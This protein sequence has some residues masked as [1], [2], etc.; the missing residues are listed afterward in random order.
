MIRASG[1][2]CVPLPC[3]H[4]TGEALTP[5]SDALVG[6][7]RNWTAW[8]RNEPVQMEKKHDARR[9]DR[10]KPLTLIHGLSSSLQL[11]T[12]LAASDLDSPGWHDVSRMTDQWLRE[13]KE[14]GGGGKTKKGEENKEKEEELLH[15]L[16]RLTCAFLLQFRPIQMG[17]KMNYF[18]WQTTQMLE[19]LD[20]CHFV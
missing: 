14:T 7:P 15:E 6:A 3:N 10:S 1:N 9:G 18:H 12:T 11:A 4:F 19:H 2:I 16:Q 13:R 17:L 20:Q 8:G 5:P